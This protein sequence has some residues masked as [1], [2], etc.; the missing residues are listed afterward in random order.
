MHFEIWN[1]ENSREMDSFLRNF[2]F[3]EKNMSKNN[4]FLTNFNNKWYH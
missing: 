2:H 3:R 1:G 4:S